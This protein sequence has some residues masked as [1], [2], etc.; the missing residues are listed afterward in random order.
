MFLKKKTKAPVNKDSESLSDSELPRTFTLGFV[1]DGAAPSSALHFDC[2]FFSSS[3]FLLLSSSSAHRI[4]LSSPYILLLASFLSSTSELSKRLLVFFSLD[5]TNSTFLFLLLVTPPPSSFLLGPSCHSP[6]AANLSSSSPF[7]LPLLSSSCWPCPSNSHS[8]SFLCLYRPQSPSSSS[9]PLF[10][11]SSFSISSSVT[12]RSVSMSLVFLHC[13]LHFR[14]CFVVQ[15]HLVTCCV[16]CVEP[17]TAYPRT[18]PVHRGCPAR[19]D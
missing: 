12:S 13:L 2:L 4:F 8:A 7:S 17:P 16:R 19:T 5:D 3:L 1:F 6:P 9:S 10:L 11:F 14:P 18:G 15:V